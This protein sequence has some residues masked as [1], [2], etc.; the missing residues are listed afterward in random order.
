MKRNSDSSAT[1][2]V[3]RKPVFMPEPQEEHNW[4]L[5]MAGEW[6]TETEIFQ[7][8]DQPPLRSMGTETVRAIG[9]FW[10]LAE[11]TG[12]LMDQ[13]F[14]GIMALG[15]DAA[16]QRYIGT[17]IDSMN[18]HLWLYEG[19]LDAARNRLT[20]QAEGPS[21]HNPRTFAKF[22]E[23]IELKTPNHRVFTSAMQSD[24]NKDWITTM[25]I[26]YRRRK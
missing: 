24:N 3:E 12:T 23:T 5:Q 26:Q 7:E 6:S 8:P 9:S 14:T 16:K 20:L 25:T 11:N 15:Y 21:P 13:P 4:L 10:I 18:S 22:R 1:M 19:T 2:E 17:W